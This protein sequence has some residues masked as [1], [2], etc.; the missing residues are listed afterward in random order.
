MSGNANGSAEPPTIPRQVPAW[1]PDSKTACTERS[2][3]KKE[4]ISKFALS[5]PPE[6]L[7]CSNNKKQPHILSIEHA[8]NSKSS[9]NPKPA[10]NKTHNPDWALFYEFHESKSRD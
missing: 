7:E 3:S 4:P 5:L 9:A 8:R 6:S 10:Q 1:I 2:K